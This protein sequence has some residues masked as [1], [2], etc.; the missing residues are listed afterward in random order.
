M[1][2]EKKS[3][4]SDLTGIGKAA[5]KLCEC[6]SKGCG[7]LYE[8]THIKRMAKANAFELSTLNNVISKNNSELSIERNGS[9]ITLKNEVEETALNYMIGKEAKKLG[10]TTKVIQNTANILKDVEDVSDEPVDDDWITRFFSIAENI[11]NEEM[12]NLWSQILA[13][14]I[15]KPNSYS[16]RTLETLKNISSKE[17]SLF[18]KFAKI[19]FS[20]RG[21]K[22]IFK[23]RDY[24]NKFEIDVIDI[25]LIKEL[26]LVSE[27]SFKIPPLSTVDIICS[28]KLL[29]IEN[30]KEDDKFNIY[31]IYKL[32]TIGEEISTLVEN[33][34]YGIS[35]I[36]QLVC[37]FR[38][39]GD[40]DIYMV[41]INDDNTYNENNFIK[42]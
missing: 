14:E 21:D 29:R 30:H 34:T 35:H 13:G 22:L 41:D 1:S 19:C 10:N 3:L 38:S 24:L 39:K 7:I 26:N 25:T 40:L 37:K 9:K 16:L 20:L 2:E 11:S 32:T 8:P 33:N 4:F 6:V 5:E 31:D 42:L 27:L 18:N 15:E 36:D 23:D 17:A 12:Q 28:D